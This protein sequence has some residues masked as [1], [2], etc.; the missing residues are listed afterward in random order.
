MIR[1]NDNKRH[2]EV[3]RALNDIQEMIKHKQKNEQINDEELIR[4]LGRLLASMNLDWNEYEY[5][6][7]TMRYYQNKSS[8]IIV[9]E[10]IR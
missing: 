6:Q 8:G 10:P 9:E 7:A 2:V 4:S 5:M 1:S 3:V